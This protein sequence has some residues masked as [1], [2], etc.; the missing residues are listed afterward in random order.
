MK[1]ARSQREKKI[2]NNGMKKLVHKYEI[3]YGKLMKRKHQKY[4]EREMKKQYTAYRNE[5]AKI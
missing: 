3:Y 1:I 2:V 5:F 4:E